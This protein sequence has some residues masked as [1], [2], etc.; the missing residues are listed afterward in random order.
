[1]SYPLIPLGQLA[2]FINGDRGKNYPSKDSFVDAGIPFINAG[3]LS[4]EWVLDSSKF[5]YISEEAY[6]RLSSGKIQKNDILFCLRGSVGK[7][8][9]IRDDNKGALASSLVI[10]RGN[11]KV[12]VE[13]LKHYLASS[14]CTKELDNYQ[15][16]AAQPNLSANDFKKFLVPLPP[17]SEQ[18]RIAAIL[19][20][21]DELRQKR[22]KAI[23][24]LDQLLQSTFYDY[25][26]DPIQNTK[27]FPLKDFKSIIKFTGGSQPPKSIFSDTCK[28]G[29]VRL[30]QI[31]DFR[32]DKYLTFI[33]KDSARRFFKRN[34][35]MIGRYG[36]PVFQ[37][38]RGLEG[39]YN[40]ALMKAE[41][42]AELDNDFLFYLLAVQSIQQLVIANSQRSAGQTGVNLEFLNN[43]V[44]G[45][46]PL[47]LQKVWAKI[48]LKI[49]DQKQNLYK[50]LNIQNQLFSSLQNQAFNGTL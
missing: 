44:I 49:E 19:D 17:L 46:P 10:L 45:V 4:D 14:L 16:G 26:G 43:L 48:A 22:Q 33:P 3:C 31:R 18:R 24:K 9:V 39:A 35:V 7:F 27:G 38:L 36:P 30:V 11:D 15:N 40:V 34:D 25:F 41:P 32:T 42:K 6:D 28:E 13:Y 21:A 2:K 20:Q 23:E 5:N 1:M 12:D 50:Q 8:A 47:E 29:Y 37:I